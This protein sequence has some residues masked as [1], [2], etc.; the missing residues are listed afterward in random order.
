[1]DFTDGQRQP[2]PTFRV[3]K[4]LPPESFL[5][6]QQRKSVMRFVQDPRRDVRLYDLHQPLLRDARSYFPDRTPDRHTAAS[7]SARRDVYEV[8]DRGGAGWRGAIITDEVGDPWLIHV[9]RHDAFHAHVAAV[10]SAAVPQ[11]VGHAPLDSRLPTRADYKIRAREERLLLEFAW[12]R[13]VLDRLFTGIVTALHE[14]GPVDLELPEPPEH[15]EAAALTI[16]FEGHD[17]PTASPSG[18]GLEHS[19]SLATLELRCSDPSRRAVEA[20]LQELL[21]FLCREPSEFD[22]QYDLRG[23]LVIWLSVSQAKLAQIVA[24][25][26]LDEPHKAPSTAEGY[27]TTHLHYVSRHDLAEALVEELPRQA[28]CGQWFVPTQD[29]SCGVP[30]CPGCER[31]LPT[32]ERVTALLRRRLSAE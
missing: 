32:A 2:R 19:S 17:W 8:R 26:Q 27:G 14:S 10:L 13:G 16:T 25:A 12:R 3:L 21:P 4:A 18:V 22:A 6:E 31:E 30:L 28:A 1:M 5:D 23:N 11:G 20:T 7:K 9:D 29:S 15:A 24:A